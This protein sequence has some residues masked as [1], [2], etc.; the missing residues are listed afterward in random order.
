MLPV[1]ITGSIIMN[2]AEEQ[3][4]LFGFAESRQEQEAEATP[5]TAPA[6]AQVPPPDQLTHV[7]FQQLCIGFI[8]SL[9]PDAI[10]ASV[11][12]RRCR[13]PVAAAGFWRGENGRAREVVRTVAVV[14]ADRPDNC[15]CECV[16]QK[17]MLDAIHAMR[18]EKERIEGEIRVNEPELASKDD[19][20][21]EFR[22]WDYAS[23]KNPAYRKL[24]S[25]LEKLQHSLYQGS[26]L[27]RIRRAAVADLCYLAVPAGLVAP[28][29]IEAG[30]GLVY[31]NADRSFTMLRDA[32]LQEN[33]EPR[34]RRLLAQNI[35][36][37]ATAAVLFQSGVDW[38]GETV[39][40]RRPPRR[41]QT[42]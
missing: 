13:Y 42:R 1:K 25:K 23:S 11:S 21:G 27:E 20:F 7:D 39:S 29:E 8:A 15:F 26:R 24:R 14:L 10:A 32:E 30:W 16:D 40:F 19:L 4:D 5:S 41:R 22:S 2:N 31:L 3:L 38:D 37:A 28:D 6:S 18:D 12:V 34:G 17:A 33:V 36:V 9:W 35:A